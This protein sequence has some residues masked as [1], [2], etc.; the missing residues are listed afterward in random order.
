LTKNDIANVLIAQKA[1]VALGVDPKIMAQVINMQKTV[2]E[3]GVP[4]VEIA[5]VL[6]DGAMPS[7]VTEVMVTPAL[8]AFGKE[9]TGADVDA[10]VNLYDNLRLKSNIPIEAVE[11]IDNTL[12]QVHFLRHCILLLLCPIMIKKII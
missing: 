9:I 8:E 1:M 7:E 12:I 5:R 6:S 4:A 2:A 3:N 11:Y 10:F